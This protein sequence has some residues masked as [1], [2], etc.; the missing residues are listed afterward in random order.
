MM[1]KEELLGLFEVMGSLLDDPKWA[2]V[3]PQPCTDT[4]W[5]GVECEVGQDLQIFHVTKILVTPDVVGSNK[6]CKSEATLSES[7]VKLPFLRTLSL[8]NCFITSLVSI[9]QVLFGAISTSLEHLALVS[10]P[11]LSGTIPPSLS[12]LVN[13][14]VLCLSQNNLFGE[15]PKEIGKLVNLVQLDLSYNNFSGTIPQEIGQLTSLRI[16]DLSFNKFYGN[17][18][19]LVGQLE[20]LEKVDLSSNNFQGR[21][22]SELGKLK[23]LVLLDLSHNSINGPLPENLTTLEK[24]QYLMLEGN[25]I[26]TCL[27][28]FIG[29]LVKLTAISFSRCGLIC[30]IPPS[31]FTNLS[32]LTALSLDN[33]NLNGTVPQSL[34]SLPILDLLNLSNNQ[35]SGE[36]S[37][38]QNFMVKLGKRLDIRGNTKLCTKYKPPSSS[39]KCTQ[40]QSCNEDSNNSK[41]MRPPEWDQVQS[42]TSSNTYRPDKILL[43]L[44]LVKIYLS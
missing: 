12:N 23:K 27:P 33:N 16:L 43:F 30:P 13:L 17:V 4:P 26:N 11:S 40:I 2:Q 36:L 22:P 19:S 28:S 1:E 39:C 42:S 3:H 8:F 38:P 6:P 15:F 35:F 32:N 5:P 31:L 29:S 14:K 18:P 44:L 7:L 24:L 25:Q 9:P 34:S 10:N 37:F 20:L 41:T 21:L